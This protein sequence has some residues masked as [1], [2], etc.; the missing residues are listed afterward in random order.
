MEIDLHR[1]LQI[2]AARF[3]PPEW[4]KAATKGRRHCR[5]MARFIINANGL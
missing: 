1:M 5:E 4:I 3:L 2:S